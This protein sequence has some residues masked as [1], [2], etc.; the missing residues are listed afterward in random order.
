[1][2]IKAINYPSTI[3]YA[4]DWYKTQERCIRA[5]SFVFNSVPDRYKAVDYNSYTLDLVSDW[6]K[7]K[8]MCNKAVN[9][10]SIAL[11]FVTDWYKSKEMCDEIIPKILC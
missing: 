9:D 4:P 10:Y 7:S 8:E 6:Y 1:M 3:K 5:Y 11:E 2:C